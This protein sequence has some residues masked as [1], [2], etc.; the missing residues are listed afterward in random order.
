M[1]ARIG[2][3]CYAVCNDQGTLRALDGL[4]PHAG[5]PLGFGN[6]SE[7]HIVCPFHLWEFDCA[8]GEYDANPRFRVATYPV[9]VEDGEILIDVPE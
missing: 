4:C 7:G 3:R 2:E 1:E 5:A 6:L 8:T 9:R